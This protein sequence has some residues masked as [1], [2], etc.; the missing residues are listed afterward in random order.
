MKKDYNNIKL[1]S[2]EKELTK[3]KNYIQKMAINYGNFGNAIYQDL[4]QEGIIAFWLAYSRWKPGHD[5]DLTG[6]AKAYIRGMQLRYLERCSKTIRLTGK[7]YQDV[8]KGLAVCETDTISLSLPIEGTEFMLSDLVPTSDP[9]EY[10]DEKTFYDALDD[11]II[12]QFDRDILKM[13]YGLTPYNEAYTSTQIA[14]K[15]GVSKKDIKSKLAKI[16][17][18][19]RLSYNF[20]KNTKGLVK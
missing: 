14:E 17:R 1:E 2:F 13:F 5:V 18:N 6:Y 7:H 9:D 12:D 15:Y 4:I 19:L 11:V 3:Y 20:R 8:Y 16:R 10:L